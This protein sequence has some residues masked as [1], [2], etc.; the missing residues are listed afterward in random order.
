MVIIPELVDLAEVLPELTA[1][2]EAVGFEARATS[3]QAAA[4]SILRATGMTCGH[5]ESTVTNALTSLATVEQAAAWADVGMAVAWHAQPADVD[6]QAGIDAITMAGYDGEAYAVPHAVDDNDAVTS[7]PALRQHSSSLAA[8]ATDTSASPATITPVVHTGDTDDKADDGQVQLATAQ[9]TVNGMTC[10]SCVGRIERALRAVPGVHTVTVA[11]T[12]AAATAEFD[13]GVVSPAQLV[14]AVQEVGYDSELLYAT[15]PGQGSKAGAPNQPRQAPGA[16]LAALRASEAATA[17]AWKARTRTA[18]IGSVPLFIMYMLIPWTWPA[19]R[20]ALQSQGALG[21]AGLTW[22]ALLGALLAT[23]VQVLSGWPFIKSAWAG[24]RHGSAGMD[25]LVAIGTSVAYGYSMLD[26]LL[27]IIWGSEY[28]AHDMFEA[29]ALLLAFLCGG[30]YMESKMRGRASDS[31]TSLLELQP[32]E[33][34]KLAI[35]DVTEAVL[36]FPPGEGASAHVLQQHVDAVVQA[37]QAKGITGSTAYGGIGVES[38]PIADVQPGH[39]LRVLP[40]ASVPVD[41]V[42]LH[43]T[44]DLDESALTGESVPRCKTRGDVVHSATV[45]TTGC[46]VVQALRADSESSLSRVISLVEQAQLDKA[47]AQEFA[48]KV[49][50]YFVPAVLGVAL[51]TFAVWVSVWM[52]DQLPSAWIGEGSTPFLFSLRFALAV[53]VVACPC[54]LGLATPTA[55]MVGTGVAAQH[56]LLFKGGSVFEAAAAVKT[57]VLDKTGTI[58]RGEPR[59]TDVVRGDGEDQPAPASVSSPACCR[60]PVAG[61]APNADS[62]ATPVPDEAGA[63]AVAAACES[64]EGLMALAVAVE[65]GSEHPVARA[66]CSAYAGT[67]DA[68]AFEPDADSSEVIPGMGVRCTLQG[69]PVSV[70]SDTAAR[71]HGT[72]LHESTLEAMSKLRSEGKTA[73]LLSVAGRVRA[74]IAARDVPRPESKAAISALQHSG[75]RVVMLTG[76]ARQT[77]LAIAQEVGITPEDVI[78][79]TSPEHKARAVQRLQEQAGNRRHSVAFVGDGINDAPALAVADVGMAMASGTA[80]AMETGD[81]VLVRSTLVDVVAAL[82]LASAV[83]AR[84][85][86]NLIWALG[87]NVLCIPLAAGVFYPVA[88][89]GLPPEA[90]GIAM[91]L[92]S[93]SVLTSSLLLKQWG[94]SQADVQAM[95]APWLLRQWAAVRR[96]CGGSTSSYTVVQ[97]PEGQGAETIDKFNA[98]CGCN[99][100]QCGGNR[101]Y[102]IQ[103][104]R[105]ESMEASSLMSGQ[106][107][108]CPEC[109][110]ADE[111]IRV[112]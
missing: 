33:A 35:S 77:A 63:S 34:E 58:T 111:R 2:V 48:D 49:S 75:V 94:M 65:Q 87:Y 19:A 28:M 21:I 84:I 46:L 105:S 109:H 57:V 25:L 14:H 60:P 17:A 89:I 73:V 90:A 79:D 26:V 85:R 55:V 29:A 52:S 112:A 15:G 39:I 54:A 98:T 71:F 43:G 67:Y 92:S 61:G 83:F 97:L 86:M 32:A 16:A 6:A 104:V 36:R 31:I 96:L 100:D 88:Q 56:G 40:G 10:A 38:V 5:C 91:A 18:I 74:I 82:A 45:N 70:F 102:S 47:P 99:C 107:G 68:A 72:E 41:A 8:P 23:P 78:A 11:L 95:S 37:L 30:K 13:P 101:W 103:S 66:I 24:L 51:V 81:V 12:M 80:I 108:C 53:I 3:P 76:D 64:V 42:V 4:A 69:V 22:R 93:V 1:A 110:C 20:A 7:G 27:A 59:V 106:T 44:S 50:A 62:G 9:L